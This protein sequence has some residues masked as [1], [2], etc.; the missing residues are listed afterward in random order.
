[1]CDRISNYFSVLRARSNASIKVVPSSSG[2]DDRRCFASPS[3]SHS[4][5]ACILF[6]SALRAR[7]LRD[8]TKRIPRS[9]MPRVR[10]A[11][12]EIDAREPIEGN[13]G[14]KG[15]GRNYSNNGLNEVTLRAKPTR[16][17]PTRHAQCRIDG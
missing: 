14:G 16:Y 1:M 10:D 9:G 6:E 2:Y 5:T 8:A 3:P 13:G 4:G 12:I 7:A 17:I 11:S 15:V